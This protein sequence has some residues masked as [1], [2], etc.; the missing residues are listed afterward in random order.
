MFNSESFP[1]KE[2]KL[3]RTCLRSPAPASP[4]L[5]RTTFLDFNHTSLF[6]CV[7]LWCRVCLNLLCMYNAGSLIDPYVFGV[8]G[9]E[10]GSSGNLGNKWKAAHI[11]SFV[12][13]IYGVNPHCATSLGSEISSWNLGPIRGS[14]SLIFTDFI[15]PGGEGGVMPEL[16][17]LKSAVT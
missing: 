16:V 8:W 12:G 13:G 2:T 4:G 9:R 7:C 5:L 11:C 3:I 15:S 14:L 17:H 6:A 1:W 10:G